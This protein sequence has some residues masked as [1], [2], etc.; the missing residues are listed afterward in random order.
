MIVRGETWRAD[1]QGL[2]AD[3]A[4]AAHRGRAGA[5]LAQSPRGHQ[6]DLVEVE[7]RSALAGHPRA[8][9]SLADLLRARFSR[10]DNDGTWA[11]LLEEM[12]VKDDSIGSVELTVSIDSTIAR[13]HQH[14]AGARK[15]GDEDGT[16]NTKESQRRQALG[17]SRG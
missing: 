1:R 12:Q 5:S 9:R 11:R 3:R 10:W 14:A 16:I 7:D 17:R 6:R 4:V 2:A 13:A 8:L 15:K